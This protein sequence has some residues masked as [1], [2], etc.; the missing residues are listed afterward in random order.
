[1]AFYGKHGSYYEIHMKAINETGGTC[2]A[3]SYRYRMDNI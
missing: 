1:M 3:K 2:K